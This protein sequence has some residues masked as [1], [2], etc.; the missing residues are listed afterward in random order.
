M[1]HLL[2]NSSIIIF[3]L[4][5]IAEQ[6]AS[7][8]LERGDRLFSVEETNKYRDV[9]DMARAFEKDSQEQIH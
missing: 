7:L 5:L 9:A 2:I 8:R 4:G 1:S 6:I 3:M